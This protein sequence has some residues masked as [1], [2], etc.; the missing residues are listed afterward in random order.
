MAWFEASETTIFYTDEGEGQPVLCLHGWT[1]D[2]TDW[3]WLSADLGR[4]HR[5]IVMDQRG[6]GRSSL[7]DGRFGAIVMAS[8]AAELLDE[9]G[10]SDAIVVGHSM[11][12]LVASALAVER[13]ELVRSLVL[14]DPVFGYP[15]ETIARTKAALEADPY[16]TALA[17][18]DAFTVDSTPAWLPI[19]HRRRILGTS[20]PVLTGALTALF[21]GPEAVGEAEF[22]RT[23][24]PRRRCPILSVY[25]GT[26]DRTVVWDYALPHAAH[27][28][29]EIWDE[30]GHFLHQEQP[31]RFAATMRHWLETLPA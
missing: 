28:L 2:G 24:L 25:A 14:V 12:T 18:F 4:D 26:S 17:I 29:I 15:R 31:D 19:W 10:V 6:H 20:E 13:P 7:G 23:Y 8:D 27:D 30:A 5:M 16:G 21:N 3:S 1:C 22:G 11:G 9:L